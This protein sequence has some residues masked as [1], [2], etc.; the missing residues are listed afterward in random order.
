MSLGLLFIMTSLQAQ[1][2]IIPVSASTT[3]VPQFD[4]SLVSTFNGSGLD[5]FPSLTTSHAMSVF[6][7]SFVANNEPGTIDFDLGGSYLV[8]GIAFWNQNFFG[9]VLGENGIQDVIISSSNDGVTYT[10][11][12]GAPNVFAQALCAPCAQETISFPEVMASFIRFDVLSNYGEPTYV[13][14]SEVAFSGAEVPVE[15]VINPV[16]ATS[17][18]DAAGTDIQNAI[19]GTGLDVFP[20]LS[21]N[22]EPTNPINS[23]ISQDATGVI[24][25]DLGGL[26]LVDGFAFWNQN[27]G[28]PGADGTSG[29]KD[30]IIYASTDGTNYNL[31]PGAPS[32]FT[33]VTTGPSAPEVFDFTAL[34]ASFI[35]I[36]VLNNYGDMFT[37]FGEVAFSGIE[38]ILQID[39]TNF[40]NALSLY[41]NPS[42]GMITISNNSSTEIEGVTIYDIDGRLM[43][44]ATTFVNATTQTID[45]SRLSSGVY[46][47]HIFVGQANVIKRV[48]KK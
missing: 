31:I 3:L 36:E 11:I 18:L 19:D 38:V 21:A 16:S 32:T 10:P 23:W 48:I 33:Q 22:H 12:A 17:T 8:D 24:D 37:G 7:N 30:V 15:N 4:T 43:Q 29:I 42:L 13:A 2:I 14:F 41:P 27:G 39:D 40:S 47:V 6:G 28:G 35:R 34:E 46:M 25:F 44:Q 20:S 5:E 26:F 1:D 45:L 9:P